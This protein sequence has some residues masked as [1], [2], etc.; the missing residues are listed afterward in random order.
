MREKT[1][2]LIILILI[3]ANFLHAAYSEFKYMHASEG[4]SAVI[5]SIGFAGLVLSSECTATR[6]PILEQICACLGDIPGSYC[7]HV[8]CAIVGIPII[9]N[10]TDQIAIINMP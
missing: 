9:G 7:Y 6:N 4:A 2:P 1:I 10:Q 5:R 8:S 3:S